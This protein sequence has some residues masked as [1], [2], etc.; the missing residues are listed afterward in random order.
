LDAGLRNLAEK[1]APKDRSIGSGGVEAIT[2]LPVQDREAQSQARSLFTG[3]LEMIRWPN[4]EIPGGSIALV[5]FNNNE[6]Q[7]PLISLGRMHASREKQAIFNQSVLKKED[8]VMA[9]NSGLSGMDMEKTTFVR[10]C[11]LIGAQMA[12]F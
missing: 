8:E 10:A 6:V 3:T 7:D 2:H 11:T 9:I 1:V 4:P 5:A 12:C